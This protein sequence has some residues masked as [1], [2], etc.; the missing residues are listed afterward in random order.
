MALEN[1][2]IDPNIPLV[3]GCGAAT[4]AVVEEYRDQP[5]CRFQ[6]CHHSALG[7]RLGGD[8]GGIRCLFISF[9]NSDEFVIK[10]NGNSWHAI[11][12]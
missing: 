2:T 10:F 11:V 9:R 7:H 4:L 3:A 8:G 1:E 12:H 5:G 6:L